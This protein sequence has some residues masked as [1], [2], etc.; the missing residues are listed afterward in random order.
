MQHDQQ[1]VPGSS[2][3]AEGVLY[4]D[5]D[6]ESDPMTATVLSGPSNGSLTFN[7]DGTFTYTPNANFAGSDSFTYEASDG[8]ETSDPATVNISVMN[9]APTASDDSY[10]T[11]HDQTLIINSSGALDNDSDTNGDPLNGTILSLPSNGTLTRL[12]DTPFAVNDP[13]DGYFKYTPNANSDANDS[14]T[15][16][17]TDGVLGSSPSSATV[18]IDVTNEAPMANDDSYSTVHDQ[19]LTVDSSGALDNDSDTDGDPFSGVILSLP[20]N[21]TLRKLDNTAFVVNDPFDGYFKYVPAL[22]WSGTDTFTYKATDGVGDSNAA[23]VSVEVLPGLNLVLTGPTEVNEGSEWELTITANSPADSWSIDW[24]DG[25]IEPFTGGSS[26]LTVAHTYA[27][28]DP[29]ATPQDIYTV[30]VTATSGLVSDNATHAITVKNVPV[31]V[32]SVSVSPSSPVPTD[33]TVTL[34]VGLIDPSTEDE[35]EYFIRWGDEPASPPFDPDDA[36]PDEVAPGVQTFSASHDYA[37]PKQ[38]TIEI[39]VK[40]DDSVQWSRRTT[41]VLIDHRPV[42][43]ADAYTSFAGTK[44]TVTAA[45]GVLANDTDA[46]FEGTPPVPGAAVGR[47]QEAN[48][49]QNP[50]HGTL[51]PE[52]DGSFTY[53]PDRGYVGDDTFYYTVWD[54]LLSSRPDDTALPT[55]VTITLLP[56][57][58]NIPPVA[59]DD[60]TYSVVRNHQLESSNLTTNQ[61]VLNNDTDQDVG[62]TLTVSRVTVQPTNGVIAINADGTFTYTPNRNYVGNDSFKYRATDGI[63]ESNEVTVSITVTY[64]INMAGPVGVADTYQDNDPLPPLPEKP[65]DQHRGK[66]LI[67]IHFD[68]GVLANDT[69]VDGDYL[70]ARIVTPPP[71][72]S[73]ETFSFN[74]DGSF[75][76]VRRDDFLQDLTFQYAVSDGTV[77]SS[78]ITVTLTFDNPAMRAVNDTYYL[79]GTLSAPLPLVTTATYLADLPNGKDADDDV[80]NLGVLKNDNPDVPASG[81]TVVTVTPPRYGSLDWN[82]ADGSFTYTPVS[83]W[84]KVAWV[85]QG[86]DAQTGDPEGFIGDTFTY[87]LQ[88]PSTPDSEIATVT[89]RGPRRYRLENTSVVPGSPEPGLVLMGGGTDVVEAFQWMIARANGGDFVVLR[90]SGDVMAL[91]DWI[92]NDLG[93]SSSLRS[94]ETLVL[95]SVDVTND[96][97]IIAAISGAEALFIAGGDQWQYLQD[98]GAISGALD[99]LVGNAVLGGTSA[100]MAILGS[101]DYSAQNGTATSAEALSNPYGTRMQSLTTG[102]LNG[103]AAITDSHFQ[104]R[105]RMGRLLAF[106]AR[107]G[108][109]G[110]GVNESTAVLISMAGADD[111][112]AKVVGASS[113][114]FVTSLGINT[115]VFGSPLDATFRVRRF[116]SGESFVFADA[117]NDSPSAYVLTAYDRQITSG[118]PD[119]PAFEGSSIY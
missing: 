24:G 39:Y 96:P 56:R 65:I 69:D 33:S 41:T 72:N 94:V 48:V 91:T 14:F 86:V 117:W 85:D 55:K 16:Q 40:D 81:L 35:T 79:P 28:D 12:D 46:D 38:Y 43:N 76:F 115:C 62:D 92:W 97:S 106:V 59:A 18:W 90:H 57:T 26:T 64:A 109:N 4:N 98:W 54:G 8:T 44:L 108:V 47:K 104:E 2:G 100:G 66:D 93:G 58:S 30:T 29:T 37:N 3:S 74:P 50:L 20:A 71:Q 107:S 32:S 61:S 5:S 15:Y 88:R 89:I 63:D 118:L 101:V 82:S 27:D 103:V 70:T 52:P 42:A 102:F 60:A 1:L 17:I 87:K 116:R 75:R 53:V 23:T 7:S 19:T 49:V 36:N 9:D 78:P 111:G 68:K 73:F 84:A 6:P 25:T 45:N 99:G 105:D 34:T 22:N 114:Y 67:D 10:S 31:F 80:P 83:D 21:G 110:L 77:E 113:A 95:D 13:F 51:K 112:S 11:L 119:D